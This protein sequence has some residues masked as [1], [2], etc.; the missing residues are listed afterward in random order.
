MPDHFREMFEALKETADGM[1][2]AM[3]GLKRVADAALAAQEEHE[4]LRHEELR[5]SVRR[6]EETVMD[7]VRRLPP[8]RSS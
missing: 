2:M 6:L 3:T 7:L 8:E 5:E 4:E 1:I